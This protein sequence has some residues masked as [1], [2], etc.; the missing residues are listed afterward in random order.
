MQF[1]DALLAPAGAGGEAIDTSSAA[2]LP[3]VPKAKGRKSKVVEPRINWEV[4]MA[5]VKRVNSIV[6]AEE[7][8]KEYWTSIA[9]SNRERAGRGGGRWV[10]NDDT[11]VEQDAGEAVAITAAT[12]KVGSRD[13]GMRPAGSISEPTEKSARK[14]LGSKHKDA[15]GTRKASAPASAATN[16][17]DEEAKNKDKSGDKQKYRT[18]THDKHHQRD[19]AT[20]KLAVA[21][22]GFN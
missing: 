17:L 3:S 22:G 7:A 19:R 4:R 20:R 1:E 21:S 16:K 13:H 9:N 11:V 12:S 2:E 8:E 6:L 18:K 10:A 5:E 14:E 15:E